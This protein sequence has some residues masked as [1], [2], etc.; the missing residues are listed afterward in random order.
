MTRHGIR[1]GS[2]VPQVY[3]HAPDRLL[4]GHGP[5]ARGRSRGAGL[6]NGSVSVLAGFVAS[7]VFA[8]SVVPMLVK[9]LRSKDLASYSRGNLVLSNVGNAVYSI[10]VFNLPFGPI[11]LLH[12]FY[13]A[14]S[15]LML[16]WSLRYGSDRATRR[17]PGRVDGVMG[18]DRV[19]GAD[20]ADERPRRIRDLVGASSG[21]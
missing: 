17:L 18:V 10:Y 13:I 14:T 16:L 12:G 2:S 6:V 9:A 21:V 11:W 8:A 5:P 1:R 3:R 19:D 15:A 20:R 7:C 4:T